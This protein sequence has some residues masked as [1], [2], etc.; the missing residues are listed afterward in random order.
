MRDHWQHVMKSTLKV[1]LDSCVEL[2]DLESSVVFLMLDFDYDCP[3]FSKFFF[4]ILFRN[5]LGW[6]SGER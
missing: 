4:V 6:F 5:S 1:S 2:V 3:L